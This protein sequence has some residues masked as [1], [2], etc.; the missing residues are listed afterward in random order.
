MAKAKR[1]PSTL[2]YSRG[3]HVEEVRDALRQTLMPLRNTCPA[4]LVE[5]R[6]AE[7][8]LQAARTHA[9]AAGGGK[10][11]VLVRMVAH[12][13]NALGRFWKLFADDCMKK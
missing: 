8:R 1:R 9:V 12:R 7:R 6:D 3:R 5:L 10:D 4:S 13:Q 2:G 11:D